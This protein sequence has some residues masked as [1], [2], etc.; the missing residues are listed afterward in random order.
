MEYFYAILLALL[1]YLI[2]SIPFGFIIGKIKGIDI[3][4][5]GSKNV[6]STNVTRVLG[7]KY[8]ALTFLMDCLVKGSLMIWIIT[9]LGES[10]YIFEGIDIRIIY[11]AFSVVGHIFPIFL[12]F[13]GGKAVATGVGVMIGVNPILGISGILMFFIIL[14]ITGYASLG[15]I[16][17]T[18]LVGVGLVIDVWIFKDANFYRYSLW[19]AFTFVIVFMIVY[20]HRRNISNL[21]K[22]TENKFNIWKKKDK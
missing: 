5:V 6:G 10:Y 9:L 7:F 17:A 8:G 18:I 15:S 4:E 12:K 13:K 20:K 3:R 21:I 22:G 14:L 19:L 11:G 16:I 2:G 1:C